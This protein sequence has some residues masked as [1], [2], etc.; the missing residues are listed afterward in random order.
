[1]KKFGKAIVVA[2]ITSSLV[3]MPLS[4]A[5]DVEAIK[6]EK[7][8][9]QQAIN[10]TNNQLT[11]LL[12]EFEMLKGDIR[13]QEDAIKKADKDLKAAQEKEKKQYEE[14]V[15]RIKY[16]YEKG[17]GSEVA[18]L[19]G[20]ESFGELL[21]RAE[22]IQNVH[23]YDREK[24]EEFAKVKE[25]VA[26]LKTGLES[27]KKEMEALAE[28]YSSEE[29]SLK[30]TLSEMKSQM[31]DFDAQLAEAQRQ[32]EEEARRIEEEAKRVEEQQ[33]QQS[34]NQS[35]NKNEEDSSN[36]KGN[37]S[38][39]NTSK[40]PQ[41]NSSED[42]PANK[43]S[44]KPSEN[45]PSDN[46]PSKPSKPSKPTEDEKEE[47]STSKPSN[48]SKG[49]Q[50]ANTGL[51][52]VGNPY[53]YGGNSLTNGIDCSG[54]TKQIHA[55]CGI[56]GLPRTSSAQRSGGKAVTGGL[57]NALPGDVICYSGHVAIYIGGGQIVHA[58]NPAPYPKG[59]IKTGSASY[60]S[61]LA[62]RRYW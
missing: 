22:Y 15:I 50:I 60:R 25:E 45:N 23:T 61:I 9:T 38:Q 55:L 11:Q 10:S 21:N 62:I 1:M 20:A 48:T 24:L 51:Q 31:A 43:P 30:T 6:K 33:L 52:Y 26:E 49:K 8:Q 57:S 59:G 41:N 37:S 40:P 54:F 18:A 2:A 32:A 3:V 16:M 27:E 34:Q 28:V 14:M 29:K 17:E 39:G 19:L 4:A 42:K 7:A 47:E 53:V 46:K 35:N 58:S 44:N 12:T 5:P 36:D 56:S 13:N